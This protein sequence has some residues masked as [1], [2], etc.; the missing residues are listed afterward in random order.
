MEENIVTSAGAALRKNLR[1]REGQFD[2]SLRD[3]FAQLKRLFILWVA[4]SV[5]ISLIVVSV[6]A[7]VKQDSYRKLTAVISFTYDGVEKGLDPNGN[8]FYVNSIKSEEIIHEVA[9]SKN[10]AKEKEDLI[11]R[12]ITF[13]GIIPSDAIDRITAMENVFEGSKGISSTQ[14]VTDTTYYPTQYRVHFDY[15]AT[16]LSASEATDFINDMLKCYSRHF[17]DSYG[18]NKSLSKSLNAFSYEDYDYSEAIDVFDSSLTK[19]STYITQV[20]SNDTT[21]FRSDVTGYTFADLTDAIATIRERNLDKI[22]S[23]VTINSVTKD[24]ETLL[25]Y[26]MFRIEQLQRH[27]TVC[28]ETLASVNDSIAN[29]KKNTIL[30]F[31]QGQAQDPSGLTASVTSAEYDELFEKRQSIQSDLSSTAQQIN[32]YNK[33]IERLNASSQNN[34]AEKK[35]KVE[36]EIAKLNTLVNDLADDVSKTTDDYY[37]TVVFPKAYNILD[38]AHASGLDIIKHAVKDS[39]G[40]VFMICAFIFAVYVGAGSWLAVKAECAKLYGNGSKKNEKKAVKNKAKENSK[41]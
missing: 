38:E 25:T 18:Y 33:K 17:F 22:D 1:K 23:Y 32:F 31:S 34:S 11:R 21:R 37:R 40:T 4:V 7:V 15:S 8:K 39:F 41:K 19:L 24:K 16:E 13:E 14:A 27:L 6:T 12:S 9:E 28:N 10:I 20:S 30:F 5:L 35:A 3:I 36:E 26:Y 2:V 29:Y